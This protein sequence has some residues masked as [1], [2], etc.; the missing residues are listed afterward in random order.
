MEEFVWQLG[1]GSTF[2]FWDD[3]WC[4]SRPLR[5]LFSRLASKAIRTHGRACDFWLI[6]AAVGEWDTRMRRGLREDEIAQF[7]ELLGLLQAVKPVEGLEDVVMWA[8]KPNQNFF[9][10]ARI[11]MVEPR[12]SNGQHYCS[13]GG[14]KVKCFSWFLLRNLV[15]KTFRARWR[16]ME[17]TDCVLCHG[18]EEIIVHLFCHCPVASR[19]WALLANASGKLL[20]FNSLEE[21][22]EATRGM[23][24]KNDPS[25]A[26]RVWL[27]V[28]PAGVWTIWSSRNAVIF[29]GRAFYFENLWKT[30]IQSIRDWGTCMGGVSSIHIDENAFRITE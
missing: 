4:G 13:T 15:T 20:R 22:W 11:C 28:I 29:K 12:G 8:G 16:P 17:A 7:T 25:K 21:L 9:S 3:R 19:L 10:Q 14:V 2:R 27:S 26:G 24:K 6:D 1:E 23:R 18:E 5:T 30:T